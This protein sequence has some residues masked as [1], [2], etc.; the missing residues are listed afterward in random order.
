MLGDAESQVDQG[1][2]IEGIKHPAFDKLNI[3]VVLTPTC[4]MANEKASSVVLAFLLPVNFVLDINH[5][6]QELIRSLDTGEDKAVAKP[7]KSKSDKIRKVIGKLID[8]DECRRHFFLKG[9][10]SVPNVFV[11]F[12]QVLSLPFD[13]VKKCLQRRPA[14]VLSPF[15][16]KL[17]T[18]F[19][20]YMMR[21][22]VERPEGDERNQ[23]LNSVSGFDF[24]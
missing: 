23:L 14:K 24:C 1:D 16:E 17:A 19:A 10:G 3:S 9:H 7:S 22:G 18:H 12:Q 8:C 20:G 13:E 6:Y 4:Q 15:R 2:I 21:I 11:D 5:D